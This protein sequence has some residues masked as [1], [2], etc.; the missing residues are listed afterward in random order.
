MHD[1]N[2]QENDYSKEAVRE[3]VGFFIGWLTGHILIMN[4][5]ITDNTLTD[6]NTSDFEKEIK[7]N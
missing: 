2:L 3:F 5:A 6:I 4:R 1:R 7:K